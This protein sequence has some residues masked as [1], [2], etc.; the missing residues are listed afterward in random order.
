[1]MPGGRVERRLKQADDELD[2]ADEKGR[3]REMRWV[4]HDEERKG[5]DGEHGENDSERERKSA[6]F[7]AF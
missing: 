4:T 3:S 7:P 2:I 1:M 6:R 5:R